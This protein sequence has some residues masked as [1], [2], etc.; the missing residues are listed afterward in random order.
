MLID[1]EQVPVSDLE[2]RPDMDG[3][4]L[5]ALVSDPRL[6][7]PEALRTLLQAGKFRDTGWRVRERFRRTS[8]RSEGL[9][10]SF[11]AGAAWREAHPLHRAANRWLP[12]HRRLIPRRSVTDRSFLR[13]VSQ[14]ASQGRWEEFWWQDEPFAFHLR[15]VGRRST[16]P[17]DEH[18]EL[19][20]LVKLY[21]AG[22]P[23]SFP[24]TF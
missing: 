8:L 7:I 16:A 2:F 21:A 11:D 17:M 22:A 6:K 19:E 3:D 14:I 18:T 1:L 13:P 20:R 10:P 23:E 5:D 9:I 12:E 4:R 24:V 15:S